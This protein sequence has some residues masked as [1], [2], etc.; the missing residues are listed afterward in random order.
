METG[1]VKDLPLLSQNQNLLVEYLL[2]ANP[3]TNVYNKII[4]EKQSFCEAYKHKIAIKT[5][6]HISVA[7]FLAKESMEET[8]IRYIHRVCSKHKGFTVT[9][10][11]YSGFP[12]HTVYVRIQD[13]EPFKQ[14]AVQLKVIDQYVQANGCPEARLIYRPHLTIARGLN[15]SVYNKA[16]LDYSQKTFHETFQLNE[17]VLLKRSNQFDSC[18]QVNVFRFYP[19]DT[20]MYNEV[21]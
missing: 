21:A 10:N 9:L 8:L 3:D 17:L 1:V 18:K 6:P 14:L 7:N 20:N 4:E 16:M 11:N 15:N 19:P 13:P 5:K 12:P 2:V